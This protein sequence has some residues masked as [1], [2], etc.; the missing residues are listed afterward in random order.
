[1]RETSDIEKVLPTENTK[2]TKT[3]TPM[4]LDDKSQQITQITQIIKSVKSVKSV[5]EDIEQ[6]K[7]QKNAEK[8]SCPSRHPLATKKKEIRC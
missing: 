8:D 5:D 2:D 3:R 6:Q 1:M 7:T 4:E